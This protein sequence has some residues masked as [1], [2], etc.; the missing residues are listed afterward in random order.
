MIMEAGK[1]KTCRVGQQ[2]VD[3]GKSRHCSSSVKVIAGR[4]PLVWGGQ[5][6]VLFR[7]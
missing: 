4:I 2:A 3:P 1:S 6:C 7:S 5:S